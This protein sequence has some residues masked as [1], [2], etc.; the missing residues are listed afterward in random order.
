MPAFV[1]LA[2]F[3]G[4]LLAAGLACGLNLY[5]TIALIGLGSRL[6]WIELPPGLLGLEQWILIVSAAILFAAEFTAAAIPLVDAI[7][8]AVHTVIRPL[9]AGALAIVALEAAPWHVRIAAGAVTAIAALAAH[10]GKV[11]LRLIV[12]RRRTTRLALSAAEDIAAALLAVLALALPWASLAAVAI[13]A[14][15][16]VT[17]GPRLWRAAAFGV[18]ALIALR[19]GFF[20]AR[21]WLAPDELPSSIRQL[22]P[23]PELGLPDPKATRVALDSRA[24]GPWRNGWLVIDGRSAVFLYR[25]AFR[26]RNVSLPRPE[27]PTVRHGL[28]ADAVSWSADDA[29]FTLHLLKD[30]PS[31]EIAVGALQVAIR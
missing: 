3:S 24:A 25:R 9:A 30:G 31:A 28:L 29:G 15:V 2:L 21:R 12:T 17:T 6:G 19:R 16:L 22:L 5:A 10:A 7:W 8:E 18:R 14:I 23:P 27:D 4:R 13:F 26:T 20:G 11:G 1:T